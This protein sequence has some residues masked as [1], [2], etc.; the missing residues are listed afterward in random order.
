MAFILHKEKRVSYPFDD[1]VAEATRPCAKRKRRT[2][3]SDGELR[4]DA[5]LI[6]S[7]GAKKC[8]RKPGSRKHANELVF[9]DLQSGTSVINS[10]SVSRKAQAIVRSFR[11]S[12]NRSNDLSR[13]CSVQ[14]IVDVTASP[15]F[16]AAE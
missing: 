11:D 13:G 15:R 5:A 12:T 9:P 10:S 2:S 8:A 7:V 14:D 4:A 6:E 16:R 3:C 1:K